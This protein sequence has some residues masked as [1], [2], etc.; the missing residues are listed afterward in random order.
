ME[1]QWA[2]HDSNDLIVA[3]CIFSGGDEKQPVSVNE[4]LRSIHIV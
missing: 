1:K 4:F 2:L 3:V